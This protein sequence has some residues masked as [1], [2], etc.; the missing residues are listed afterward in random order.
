MRLFSLLAA[1]LVSLI[2]LSGCESQVN[3]DNFAQ[4]SVGMSKTEVENLLGGPGE[5]QEISGTNIAYGGVV[6]GS[7]P[8]EEFATYV[9]KAGRA[10]YSVRFKGGKV[11]EKVK[12]GG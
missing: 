7:N 8:S 5:K 11:V 10:E 9:W 12:A 6:A 3:D 1:A 4:I 2:A